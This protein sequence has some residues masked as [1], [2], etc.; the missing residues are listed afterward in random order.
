[1]QLHLP[2]TD[3]VSPLVLHVCIS[4]PRLVWMLVDLAELS[5]FKS[6]RKVPALLGCGAWNQMSFHA[7]KQ[8]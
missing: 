7:E 5:S 4:A 2:A 1:M 6:G 3:W 8:N